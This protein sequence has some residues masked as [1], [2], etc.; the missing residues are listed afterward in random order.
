[1][2]KQIFY[3]DKEQNTAIADGAKK[4]TK[5]QKEKEAY[6]TQNKQTRIIPIGTYG[7]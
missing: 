4:L 5:A 2:P 1:M 3:R 6:R 7:Y